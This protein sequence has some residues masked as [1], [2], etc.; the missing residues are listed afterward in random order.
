MNRVKFLTIAHTN[1]TFC[2]PISEDKAEQLLA[3]LEPIPF[4]PILDVGCG[5][6]EFLIRLCARYDVKVQ[7]PIL[8]S[9]FLAPILSIKLNSYGKR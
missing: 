8:S 9:L 6:G 2:S 1:H 7:R 5:K 4:Y 3:L